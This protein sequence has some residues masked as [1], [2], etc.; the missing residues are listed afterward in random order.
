M[1]I[2]HVID[3]MKDLGVENYGTNDYPLF[4]AREVGNLLGMKDVKS[5]VRSYSQAD[6][7]NKCVNGK[8]GRSQNCKVLTCTGLRKLLCNS[9]KPEVVDV[10]NRLGIGSDFK[11]ISKETQ[12]LC[13]LKQAFYGEEVSF[14]Y[15]VC[16]YYID[17]YFPKYDL[18][19]EFDEKFHGKTQNSDRDTQR[20]IEITLKI[21][22]TFIRI[23]E[24]DDIFDSINRIYRHIKKREMEVLLYQ[25]DMEIKRIET[26]RMEYAQEMKRL[27]VQLATLKVRELVEPNTTIDDVSDK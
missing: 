8:T 5:S 3:T 23:K 4:K 27:D 9:R 2:K 25:R 18:A 6:I 22:C 21:G 1:D 13:Q 14:Q 26:K 24:N 10:C 11:V 16:G 20:E 19:V 15:P 17:M 7:E 12:C